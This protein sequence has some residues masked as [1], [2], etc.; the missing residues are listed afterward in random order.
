MA[1]KVT[2]DGRSQM[3]A[4]NLQAQ[5]Q[6]QQL[7]QGAAGHLAPKSRL[8]S[9]AHGINKSNPG[10]KAAGQS[11]SSVGGML[12]TKSKRERSASVDSGEPRHTAPKTLEAD[13]KAGEAYFSY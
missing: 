13:A 11:A 3:A 2:G 8:S 10:P 7:Q 12:K 9:G 5:Q 4:V 6:Q 1:S